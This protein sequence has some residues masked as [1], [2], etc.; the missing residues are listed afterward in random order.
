MPKFSAVEFNQLLLSLYTVWVLQRIKKK[1]QPVALYTLEV[2]II[3]QTW[4]PM[5][6]AHSRGWIWRWE[7]VTRLK[8]GSVISLLRGQ[9]V[10]RRVRLSVLFRKITGDKQPKKNCDKIL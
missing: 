9:V 2:L 3:R 8:E 10:C 1:N 7:G 4:T 6:V 5:S